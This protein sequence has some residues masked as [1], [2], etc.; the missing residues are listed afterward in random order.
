[1]PTIDTD[2]ADL[3]LQ[4]KNREAATADNNAFSAYALLLREPMSSIVTNV[5]D[6]PDVRSVS[7]LGYN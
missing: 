5:P 3:A 7:I 4:A 6:R 2:S 1:M